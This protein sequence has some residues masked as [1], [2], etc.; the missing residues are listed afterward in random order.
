M[1]GGAII[2][3]S[4]VGGL[5]VSFALGSGASAV[6]GL[7]ISNG[8]LAGVMNK[9]MNGSFTVGQVAITASNLSFSYATATQT[10][11]LSGAARVS[12]ASLGNLS[13]T[14]GDTTSST[15]TRGLL[16][17]SGSL[18]SLNMTVNVSF[19]LASVAITATNLQLTYAS[20]SSLFSLSGTAGVSI[21]SLGNLNV[22]FGN[23]VR[24]TTTPGLSLRNGVLQSLDTAVSITGLGSLNVAFGS[25]VNGATMPGV[26]VTGGSLAL[27]D[28]TPKSSFTADSVTFTAQNLALMYGASGA[29][30]FTLSGTAI[31]SIGGITGMA[32][33][34]AP[35]RAATRVA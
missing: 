14:F 18:Q 16:V 35:P 20:A 6:P 23:S 26:V 33:T 13:V 22:T 3:V 34:T 1:S 27:L 2:S 11:S 4:G 32:I 19:T 25:T 15:L 28:M 21:A 7:V 8:T 24:G 10:F 30:K 5:S 9:T 17:T 31:V 12:V 29:T